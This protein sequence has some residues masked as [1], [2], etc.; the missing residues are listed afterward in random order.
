MKKRSCWL[1]RALALIVLL[2]LTAWA[3]GGLGPRFAPQVLNARLAGPVGLG[4]SLVN[5]VLA[6]A[7]G[8]I[9]AGG[10]FRTVNGVPRTGLVRLNADGSLDASFDLTGAT[11]SGSPYGLGV[12]ALVAQ[13]NGCLLVLGEFAD[14]PAGPARRSNRC[15]CAQY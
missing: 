3:D 8:K 10:I 1:A 4:A 5:P 14:A 15:G 7:A 13:P 9:L 6:Q 2:F 11:I 12:T